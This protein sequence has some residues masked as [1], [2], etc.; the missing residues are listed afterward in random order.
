[1]SNAPNYYCLLGAV[2]WDHPS[3]TGQFY[4]EDMPAEW[5]LSFYNTEYECVYLPYELWRTVSRETV[6]T[7]YHDTLPRFRFLLEQ[8]AGVLSSLEL[9]LVSTLADKALLAPAQF[10]AL[11]WLPENCDVKALAQELQS[12]SLPPPRYVISASADLTQLQQVRTLLH[13]LG[14]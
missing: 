3:W 11:L 8:P 4:P 12:Y 14:F 2:G 6:A 13:V 7:W 9:G 5:R 1:M 10:P